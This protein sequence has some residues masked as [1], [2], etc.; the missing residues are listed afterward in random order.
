[1][2][3]NKQQATEFYAQR[4][5]DKYSLSVSNHHE[6]EL[7]WTFLY[8]VNHQQLLFSDNCNAILFSYCLF[9]FVS[10]YLKWTWGGVGRIFGSLGHSCLP[11]H[12]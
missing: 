10:K 8:F 6:H 12:W 4:L 9:N 5:Y 1:M 2:T 11:F 7:D 3:N